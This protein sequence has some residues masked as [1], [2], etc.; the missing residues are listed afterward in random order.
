[1]VENSGNKEIAL[2]VLLAKTKIYDIVKTTMNIEILKKLYPNPSS[3]LNPVRAPT[4]R[5]PRDIA[6]SVGGALWHYT[7]EVWDELPRKLW[8]PQDKWQEGIFFPGL[9][10]LARLLQFW[11]RNLTSDK[12]Q[13]YALHI[14]EYN[15]NEEFEKAWL[16][17]ELALR[18]AKLRE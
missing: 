15:N 1:M 2:K 8:I 9:I 10:T 4:I 6:Y 11:N 18:S 5:D 17:L 14:I 16:V 13:N 12:A 3:A 7:N